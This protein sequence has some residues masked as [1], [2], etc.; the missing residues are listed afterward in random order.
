[1]TAGVILPPADTRLS[2]DADVAAHQQLGVIRFEVVFGNFFVVEVDADIVPLGN[3]TRFDKPALR[4]IK[5]LIKI[6]FNSRV[7]AQIHHRKEFTAVRIQPHIAKRGAKV[8]VGTFASLFVDTETKRQIIRSGLV[9]AGENG[10]VILA[11]NLLHLIIHV[12]KTAHAVDTNQV[13]LQLFAV[14]GFTF[15]LADQLPYKYRINPRHGINSDG[16]N[17]GDQ[18]TFI[19]VCGLPAGIGFRGHRKALQVC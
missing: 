13:D 14:K 3:V 15:L 11:I 7:T 9:F 19:F 12:V 4:L 8:N 1:M 6:H 17:G 5:R 16:I 10:E 2:P 18:F